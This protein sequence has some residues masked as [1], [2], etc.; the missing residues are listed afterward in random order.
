M[1]VA[2]SGLTFQ[3]YLEWVDGSDN[4]YQLVQ[5]ELIKLPPESELNNSIANYLFL[6]LVNAGV[7]LRLVHPHTCELQV[8]IIHPSD[9]A[10]RYPDLVVL[11][12]EHLQLVQ[13]R[14]TITLDMPPPRLVVEVVSPGDTNRQRDYQSKRSQYCKREIPEYWIIDPET[15]VV[16]VL[17]LESQQYVELGVYRGSDR[18]QS[19]LFPN[20]PLS[21]AAIFAIQPESNPNHL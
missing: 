2:G 3:E 10:N 7:P 14:L 5:G 18:V 17:R 6:V 9:P 16:T 11:C 19:S 13:R 8:P 20:L 15:A 1:A 21:A 4:R 12:E